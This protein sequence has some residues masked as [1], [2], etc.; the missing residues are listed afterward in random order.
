MLAEWDF[1]PTSP[2]GPLKYKW[3]LKTQNQRE[4]ILFHTIVSKIGSFQTLL[5]TIPAAFT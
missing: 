4:L 3:L 1:L 2:N 5:Y